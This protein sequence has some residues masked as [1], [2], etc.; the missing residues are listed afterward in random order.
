MFLYELHVTYQLPAFVVLELDV[1]IEQ[2]GAEVCDQD[3]LDVVLVDE[4]LNVVM[5]LEALISVELEGRTCLSVGLRGD[6]DSVCHILS[7]LLYAVNDFAATGLQLLDVGVLLVKLEALAL[8]SL[9]A[10]G[11]GGDVK[12]AALE[13]LDEADFRIDLQELIELLVVFVMDGLGVAEGAAGRNAVG[14]DN[15]VGSH[16]KSYSLKVV[17]FDDDGGEDGFAHGFAFLKFLFN[18]AYFLSFR[19]LRYNLFSC[20]TNF[21]TTNFGV[22]KPNKL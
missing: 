15:V 20:K 12:E 7:S 13:V 16:L 5:E 1:G 17:V 14:V 4:T 21:S 6:F 8:D 11:V 22:F 2:L 9:P 3:V 18:F 19:R 10:E